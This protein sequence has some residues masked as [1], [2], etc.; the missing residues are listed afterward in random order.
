[1]IKLT[2]KEKIEVYEKHID[3]NVMMRIND[4]I[5][6]RIDV[7]IQPRKDTIILL[8]KTDKVIARMDKK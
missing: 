1:M 5:E 6:K 4:A 2:D 8:A 3:I 7:E